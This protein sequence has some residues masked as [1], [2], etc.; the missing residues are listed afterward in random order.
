[1]FDFLALLAEVNPPAVVI[2]ASPIAPIALNIDPADDDPIWDAWAADAEADD[3]V[4][5]G[6]IL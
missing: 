3:P 5:S 4:C 6:P 1:M 2:S